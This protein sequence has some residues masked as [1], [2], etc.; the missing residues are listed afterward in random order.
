MK[1]KGIIIGVIALLSIWAIIATIVAVGTE[2]L[3]ER[4]EELRKEV[5]RQEKAY[6]KLETEYA[7]LKTKCEEYREKYI[8]SQADYT[9]HLAYEWLVDMLL[10]TNNT[11]YDADAALDKICEREE[12]GLYSKSLISQKAQQILSEYGIET[13]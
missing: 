3:V 6:E 4:N 1:T 5:K 13:E 2:A 9:L 12:L 10:N 7:D 11:E 8:A